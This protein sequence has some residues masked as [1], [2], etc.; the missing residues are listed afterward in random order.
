MRST[1]LPEITGVSM[2]QGSAATSS[3]RLLRLTCAWL[4]SG[5]ISAALSMSF[6]CLGFRMKV[7]SSLRSESESDHV[8]DKTILKP[9]TAQLLHNKQ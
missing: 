1:I 2:V 3:D 9:V 4:K 5:V 7:N 8:R 6:E